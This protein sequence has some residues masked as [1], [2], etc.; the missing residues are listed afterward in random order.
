MSELKLLF[1]AGGLFIF[2]LF[3]ELGG[4]SFVR[5]KLRLKPLYH[6]SLQAKKVN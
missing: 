2:Q 3:Q 6:G 1:R 4:G 5:L